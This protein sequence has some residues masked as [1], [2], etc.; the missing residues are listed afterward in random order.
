LRQY[1][2]LQTLTPDD[3]TV[4]LL[5][6]SAAQGIG[7]VEEAVGW[8]EKAAA[9][10]SPDGTSMLSRA[11]RATA[12]AFLAWAREDALR[13][14]ARARR[15]AAGGAAGAAGQPDAVR[16]IVTWSHP[17]LHPAL[18]TNTLGAP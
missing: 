18:W 4:T 2:T 13:L 1:L 7:R 9:A 11:A 10:G 14:V 6:A 8:A 16:V 3:P 5:I 17:E 12:S 15:L